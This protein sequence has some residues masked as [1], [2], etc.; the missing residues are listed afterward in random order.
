[1]KKLITL[2]LICIFALGL[3][4]S[5][6]F[7]GGQKEEEKAEEVYDI[8]YV[9]KLVGIPWFNAT[10]EGMIKR[11]EEL[12]VNAALVGPPDPDPAQQARV[13]EDMIAKGVDAICVVPNEAD[14]LE[15]VLGKAMEKGILVLTHES[16]GQKN[17]DYDI[18]M[19]DNVKVGELH[20]EKLAELIGGEGGYGVLVGGLSVPTHNEWADAAIAYQ[21]KNYPDMYQVT[22]RLPGTESVEESH[23]RVIEL[24]KAYPDLKGVLCFGSLGPIGAAQAVREKGMEDQVEV[25]GTALPSHAEPYLKDGSMDAGYIY[26]PIECGETVVFLSK[27]LLDG[28]KI[29]D[30][31]EIPGVGGFSLDGDV[32]TVEGI[33]E[34]TAENAGTLGF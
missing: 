2:A 10:E 29:E 33:I 24:M 23:D 34:I 21:E 18:E 14:T 31:D 22:D 26:S 30:L 27:Y 9:A 32:I 12:G 11:A 1:M 17:N 15:P 16:T 7:A 3:G 5:F 13:V 28:N 8:V 19:M 20:A 4:A 25:V 6:A